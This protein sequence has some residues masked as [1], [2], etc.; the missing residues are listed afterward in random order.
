MSHELKLGVWE[1]TSFRHEKKNPNPNF[2]VRIF[3]G[4]VGVFD[5]KG[6]GPKSSGPLKTG[7]SN[8][9]GGISR[10]FGGISRERLKS[11]RKIKVCVR[12][13]ASILTTAFSSGPLKKGREVFP[14]FGFQN[15]VCQNAH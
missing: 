6:W 4:G 8:S 3:S 11:L 12:F 15:R 9:F 14:L 10:D 1:G 13:W 2:W 7:K 5:V